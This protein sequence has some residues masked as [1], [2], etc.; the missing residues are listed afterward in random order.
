MVLAIVFTVYA[1][2]KMSIMMMMMMMNGGEGGSSSFALGSKKK[3]RCLC[4][5]VANIIKQGEVLALRAIAKDVATSR[6]LPVCWSR[7]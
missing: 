1:T 6:G 4:L 7:P 5:L 3:S 2:L